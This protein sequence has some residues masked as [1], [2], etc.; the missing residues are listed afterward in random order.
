MAPLLDAKGV[1]NTPIS[2]SVLVMQALLAHSPV[3]FSSCVLGDQRTSLHV[4]TEVWMGST[5]LWALH[6]ARFAMLL[7]CLVASGPWADFWAL[8]FI[9]LSNSRGLQASTCPCDSLLGLCLRLQN[10]RRACMN[11]TTAQGHT[12]HVVFF[13]YLSHFGGWPRTGK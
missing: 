11:G 8:L 1:T 13:L 6:G 2:L 5:S 4:S 10:L 12:D 9:L 7:G 3:P